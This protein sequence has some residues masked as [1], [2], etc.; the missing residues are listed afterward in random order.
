MDIPSLS[1]Y[2]KGLGHDDLIAYCSKLRVGD[3]VLP[4]PFAVSAACWSDS[5]SS[6]PPLSFAHIFEYFVLKSGLY[7]LEQSKN[8][9]SLEGYNYFACQ[10]VQPV[11][12]HDPGVGDCCYLSAKVLPS[13]RQG[14]KTN[15]YE[16]YL[17]VNKTDGTIVTVHYTC[18]AGYVLLFL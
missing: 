15:M 2:A 16:C 7:T 13:Q 17:V 10:H 14:Q 1:K 6:W 3:T 4:D 12:Y 11:L 5:L 18:M 8:I 9:T